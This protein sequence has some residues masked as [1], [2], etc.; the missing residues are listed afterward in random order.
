MA[1]ESND[2]KAP[3]FIGVFAAGTVVAIVLVGLR[4]WVRAKILCKVALDDWVVATSLVNPSIL[5]SY[6][7][8]EFGIPRARN[9]G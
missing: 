5:D 7:L 3:E 6:Q 8:L 4:L 1:A 2:N 9:R